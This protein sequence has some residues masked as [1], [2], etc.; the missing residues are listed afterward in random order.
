[1][2]GQTAMRHEAL[3]RGKRG[4]RLCAWLLRLKGYRILGR[5]IRTPM[6]E[7][8]ILARRGQV[9]AVVEVKSRAELM[10]AGESVTP[11]KQRRLARAA[12]YVLT[13]FPADPELT[14][15]FDAMLVAGPWRIAH[16]MDAWRDEAG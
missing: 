8:D 7:I 12:R 10:A 3:R 4:E 5:N 2:T 6:G 1:M 15:R 11:E 13:R 14:V 16:V 9:L